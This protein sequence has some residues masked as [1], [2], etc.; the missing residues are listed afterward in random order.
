M[1]SA[2]YT[3]I[4]FLLNTAIWGSTWLAIKGQLG[5]VSPVAS[6]TYRFAIAAPMLLLWCLGRGVSL[7]FPWRVHMVL[8]GQG[9][10][11]FSL[12]YLCAYVSEQY[13]SSGLVAILYSLLAVLNILG[14]RILFGA[15]LSA[16]AV[17]AAVLGIVGVAMLFFPEL[18]KHPQVLH[19]LGIGVLG[20]LFACAGNMAAIR[21][22]REKVQ[23]IPGTAW[24]LAYG[25]AMSALVGAIAGVE[26]AFDVRPVYV[27][28]L[29]YLSLF[30]T[31]VACLCYLTLLKREGA[32][33]ASY[34]NIVTPVV[35]LLLSTLFEG[36]AWTW[37]AAAGAALAL[38]GNFLTMKRPARA[39]A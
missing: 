2:V 36:H 37:V 17:L 23:I 14:A 25:A 30:G 18:S 20:V 19:G 34:V 5:L 21:S 33:L 12:N 32:A 10:C 27:F 11:F 16:R 15:P 13:V 39:K 26:W 4:L 6:V 24:A 35:A 8:V 28:S 1:H 22:Q 3:P 7:R 9:I 31:I 38:F 29:L